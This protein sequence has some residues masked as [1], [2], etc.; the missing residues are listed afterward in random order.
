MRD[1]ASLFI[2][3]IVM[4]SRLI[5]PGS[6]RSVV[7]D[8]LL[9]NHQLVILNRV[10]VRISYVVQFSHKLMQG[11]GTPSWTIFYFI[12]VGDKLPRSSRL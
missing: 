8:S 3:I 4:I 9:V 7:A 2:H 6:T 5:G 10:W 11:L 1:L 12:S